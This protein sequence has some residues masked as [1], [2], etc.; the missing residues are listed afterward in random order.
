MAVG[1]IQPNAARPTASLQKSQIFHPSGFPI[2]TS[3]LIYWHFF[4]FKYSPKFC[5]FGKNWN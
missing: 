3:I 2:F 5:S 1:K 4:D